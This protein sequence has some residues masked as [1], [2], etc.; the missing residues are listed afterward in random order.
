MSVTV[1]KKSKNAPLLIYK[2]Y[3][4]TIDWKSETKFLWKCKY[5]RKYA[6]HGRL[7]AK[8]N[9]EFIKTVG[10]HENHTSNP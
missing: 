3:S 1:S 8:L 5:S 7:H 10:E 6:G 9:D 4:Y 2:G